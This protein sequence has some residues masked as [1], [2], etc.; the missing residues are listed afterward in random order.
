MLLDHGRLLRSLLRELVA[1]LELAAL[2]SA[3][4]QRAAGVWA[5]RARAE[6]LASGRFVQLTRDLESQDAPLVVVEMARRAAEEEARHVS[7]CVELAH[8]LG[9][10][11]K[12]PAIPELTTPKGPLSPKAA[13][14]LQ[15]VGTCCINETVSAAVLSEMLRRSSPGVVHDTIHEILTDEIDHGRIG[16]AY[17][18][19][20]ASSAAAKLVSAALPHL[21]EQAVTDE[22]FNLP[23][24][25]D[26]DEACAPYGTVSRATRQAVFK[27]SLKELVFP[28]LERFSVDTAPGRAWL[29]ERSMS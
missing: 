22:L 21:L 20:V 12:A 13:L 14:L 1:P 8:A 17:L 23:E 26:P 15:V 24:D 9:A 4:R 19:H 25:D 18:A 28:G 3:V 6:A 10:S 5:Y 29:V 11:I 2:P 7:L 27:S 16:W